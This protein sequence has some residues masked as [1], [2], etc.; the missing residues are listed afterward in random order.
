[1]PSRRLL[2]LRTRALLFGVALVFGAGRLAHA[3]MEQTSLALPVDGVQFVTLY[4]AE[5]AHF[6]EQQG[7][8][9]KVVKIAGVGAFNAVIAGSVD[10]SMSSATSLVRAAAHGQRMLA[11]A[12]MNNRPSW[13][14]VL[15]QDLAAAAH[16]DGQAPLALR[17]KVLQGRTIAVQ[18]MNSVEHAYL[19]IIA[20][21]GG[22]DPESITV[23]PMQLGD[24]LGALARKAIDGFASAPP[25]PQQVVEDGSAVVVA[26]GIDGD[27]PWMTPMGNGLVI[28]RPQFC[29]DHRS[30]CMKMGHAMALSATMIHQQPQAVQAFLTK[31]FASMSRAVI[32]R[33]FAALR[34][35]TPEIPAVTPAGLANG[36]RINVAAGFMKEAD[37]L[38]SYDGLSTDEFVR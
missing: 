32:A 26:S 9:V 20:G 18:S 37:M 11:I 17:A 28:A 24:T 6:F 19:R 21:E 14:I 13:S 36:D 34:E 16:F 35:A 22:V 3:Q 23:T 12:N 30:I 25:W 27:P 29:V 1:M 2:S 10:F 8:E 15:R 4:V 7:L 31:R 5:D 33:A 38:K